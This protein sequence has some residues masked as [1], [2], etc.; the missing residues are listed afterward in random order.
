MV[1]S[2]YEPDSSE[3]GDYLGDEFS[4]VVWVSILSSGD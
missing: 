2:H 3:W 1:L 4:T